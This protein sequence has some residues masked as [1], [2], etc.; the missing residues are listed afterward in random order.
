VQNTQY[1][2]QYDSIALSIRTRY[3]YPHQAFHLPAS[4]ATNS[5]HTLTYQVCE[6]SIRSNTIARLSGLACT[7]G[8]LQPKHK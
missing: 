7:C 2:V 8:T 6:N 5:K 4:S 3:S 1:Q